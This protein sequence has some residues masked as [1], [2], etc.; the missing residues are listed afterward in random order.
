MRAALEAAAYQAREVFDAIYADS[1]VLLREL[2]VDG[3]GSHNELLMQFQA[4]MIRAPVVIPEVQETT[5]MGAAFA[6]GLAV[7]VWNSLDDVKR[8]WRKA[9]VYNPKMSEEERGKNWYG[10]K[11]AVSRSLNWVEMDGDDDYFLDAETYIH[12]DDPVLVSEGR[13]A[14]ERKT[15]AEMFE[16]ISLGALLLLASVAGAGA[17]LGFIFGRRRSP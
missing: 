6:A 14:K 3:G 17:S 1:K 10:W 12:S 9:R 15:L 16:G 5:A 7:G 2:K 11:K 13:K 8:L 4:D